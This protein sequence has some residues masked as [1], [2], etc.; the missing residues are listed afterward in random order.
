MVDEQDTWESASVDRL[1]ACFCA[2]VRSLELTD[3]IAEYLWVGSTH[4]HVCLVLNAEKVQML[5][6][7]IFREDGDRMAEFRVSFDCRVAPVD[8]VWERP[9]TTRKDYR[10]IRD[11]DIISIARAYMLLGSFGVE[12]YEEQRCSTYE[13]TLESRRIQTTVTNRIM[14]PLLPHYL[15]FAYANRIHMSVR[16][17][18]C[19]G[20]CNVVALLN[21]K[22]DQRPCL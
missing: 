14:T 22:T 11:I 1:R 6:N 7:L 3:D 8:I 17:Q 20:I 18:F 16:S 19:K 5:A 21:G 10:G 15:T 9:E 4:K 12:A 13:E 2:H